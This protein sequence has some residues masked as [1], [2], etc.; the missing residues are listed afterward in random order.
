MEAAYPLAQLGMSN[1]DGLLWQNRMSASEAYFNDYSWD[2]EESLQMLSDVRGLELRY[3]NYV[4]LA[5]AIAQ[6]YV[7]DLYYRNPDPI[8]QDKRGDRDLSKM[9]TDVMRS[10]HADTDSETKMKGA[11][12]D[13]F[14][15][16]FGMPW[17]SFTQELDQDEQ[18]FLTATSQRVLV[19]EVSPWHL[20]FD[21]RGRRWDMS[22]HSYCA[23]LF[24]PSLSTV[25]NWHWLSDDDKRRIVAYHTRSASDPL[26]A[27]NVVNGISSVNN[28]FVDQRIDYTMM[29]NDEETDPDYIQ[30]PT[31]QIWDRTK[32]LVYYQ[33]AGA[34]F[35]LTPQPWPDEF[36]KANLFPGL[37]MAKNREALNKRG[38][39][40]FIGVPDIRRIK[41]HL[42]AINRLEALFLSANQNVIFK[43]FMPKGALTQHEQTKLYSDR[44]RQVIQW[45]ADAISAFPLEMRNKI[46]VDDILKLVPQAELNELKHLEGIKHELDMIAQIMGQSPGDRGGM[47]ITKTA[48]DSAIID[49]RLK[50]QTSTQR[51]EAGKYYTKLTKRMFLVLQHRQE[52]PIQ[53][54]MTT[55]NFKEKVWSTFAADKLRDLDLHFDYAVG[56]SESRTPEQEFNLMERA[57]AILMPF[58]QATG[59]TRAQMMLVR[60]LLAPLN[61]EHID[62]Y[63]T[64][65]AKQLVI[66]LETI[67]YGIQK[68]E[69]N[70][71]DP[72]VAAKQ[73]EL[74]SMLAGKML[75]P[76]DMAQIVQGGGGGQQ[77]GG[78]QATGGPGAGS[79]PA[80][81]TPGQRA[82][83]DGA[84]GGSAT[85]GSA[86]AGAIGGMS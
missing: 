20:R 24:F 72:A 52:L 29:G 71:A 74:I 22:D 21:P 43:Y 75:S 12:L 14:W 77:G 15:A 83:A 66:Q 49:A 64:D 73:L 61:L 34:L 27:I 8:I 46:G 5:D 11:F 38:T 65:D 10:I 55:S 2:W 60:D 1:E 54:Q 44:Q 36:A 18:G 86:A 16:G 39:V 59:D 17:V 57:A 3:G 19:H 9:V 80:P 67:M 26:S 51:H 62:D 28:H 84:K 42:H 85:A 63:I 31:W 40:G 53:Y 30:I 69:I 58:L 4:M 78:G 13:Q 47:P 37:Y 50:S 41:P 32:K 7:S 33:P 35:A 70:P 68:G 79:A 45:D 6:S 48:T 82:F 25:M 81:P 56:S 23:V 76:A